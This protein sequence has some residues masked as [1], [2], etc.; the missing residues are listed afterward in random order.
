[1]SSVSTCEQE[2]FD[3]TTLMKTSSVATAIRE[4]DMVKVDDEVSSIPFDR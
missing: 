2:G 4:E 3:R 1:M